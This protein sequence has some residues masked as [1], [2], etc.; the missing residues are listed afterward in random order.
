[1]YNLLSTV[2]RFEAYE[3][4]GKL[5]EAV[6]SESIELTLSERIWGVLRGAVAAIAETFGLTDEE[7]FEGLSAT[8]SFDLNVL[9]AYDYKAA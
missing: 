6:V 3:T 9:L 7:V 1:Q 5:F 2:K 4:L 8:V